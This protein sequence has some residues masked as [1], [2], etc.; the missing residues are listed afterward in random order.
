VQRNISICNKREGGSVFNDC[1]LLKKESCLGIEPRKRKRK[2]VNSK[3]VRALF[4]QLASFAE[5]RSSGNKKKCLINDF[6]RV[7]EKDHHPGISTLD[8]DPYSVRPE[9]EHFSY[10]SLYTGAERLFEGKG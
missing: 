5:R 10:L 8:E 6:T 7:R 9:N 3:R 1:Y 4:K 2:S